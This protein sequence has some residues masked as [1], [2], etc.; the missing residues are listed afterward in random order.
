VTG[1]SRTSHNATPSDVIVRTTETI[2]DL[3]SATSDYRWPSAGMASSGVRVLG[4][5]ACSLVGRCRL[6]SAMCTDK[7]TADRRTNFVAMCMQCVAQSTPMVA[8]GLVV[9]RRR[10]LKAFLRHRSLG[11]WPFLRRA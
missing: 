6:A 4:L 3:L 7:D 10:S 9:M 8:T 1:W 11:R 2:E 5:E